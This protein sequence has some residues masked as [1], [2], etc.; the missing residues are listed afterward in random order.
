MND[1]LQIMFQDGSEVPEVVREISSRNITLVCGSNETTIKSVEWKRQEDENFS[2]MGS[3]LVLSAVTV[4][5]A[6]T[7]MCEATST[8]DEVAVKEFVLDVLCKC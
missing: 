5:D 8:D 1:S 2:V 7:Y 4:H 6:G 3:S